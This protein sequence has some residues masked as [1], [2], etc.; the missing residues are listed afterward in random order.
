[1]VMIVPTSG[2]APSSDAI[3]GRGCAAREIKTEC[4]FATD[5]EANAPW[6]VAAT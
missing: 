3:A 2:L 4:D 6:N 1:M 5:G